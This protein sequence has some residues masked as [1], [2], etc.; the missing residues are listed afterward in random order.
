[1]SYQT[2]AERFHDSMTWG[3]AAFLLVVLVGT[4]TYALLNE[5]FTHTLWVASAISLIVVLLLS[6]LVH[7]RRVLTREHETLMKHID[8]KAA[9]NTA[10]LGGIMSG[11][12]QVLEAVT[13]ESSQALA[14][15]EYREA[16][17][18]LYDDAL[19]QMT[20]QAVRQARLMDASD[21]PEN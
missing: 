7:L 9:E 14:V 20:K 12:C 19:N 6:I 17:E 3:L 8:D 21:S 18:G 5:D 1:M 13:E 2:S 11:Q 16:V 15:P 10:L 4:T